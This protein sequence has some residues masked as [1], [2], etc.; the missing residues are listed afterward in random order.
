MIMTMKM[1][2]MKRMKQR[3][4]NLERMKDIVGTETMTKMER[5]T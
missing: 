4:M 2:T 5:M 1:V 3:R